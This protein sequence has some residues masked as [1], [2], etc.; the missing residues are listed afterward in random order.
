MRHSLNELDHA[1]GSFDA[2]RGVA[3]ADLHA[4]LEASL[5]EIVQQDWLTLVRHDLLVAGDKLFALI[6]VDDGNLTFGVVNARD[7]VNQDIAQMRE[8]HVQVVLKVERAD[9]AFTL[10]GEDRLA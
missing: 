3:R 10:T 2:L 4:N 7:Q 5:T 9:I 1:V 8:R 6:R